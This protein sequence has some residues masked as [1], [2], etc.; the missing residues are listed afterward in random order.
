MARERPAPAT[1][2]RGKLWVQRALTDPLHLCCGVR[3]L[4]AVRMVQEGQLLVGSL[5][6]FNHRAILQ[7]EDVVSLRKLHGVESNAKK[8]RHA[9]RGRRS[10]DAA[11]P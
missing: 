5:R 9:A 3:V 1:F 6:L 7:A 2:A 8:R 4:A 11:F 10:A